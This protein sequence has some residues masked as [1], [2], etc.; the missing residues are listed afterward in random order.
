MTHCAVINTIFH[1]KNQAHIEFF[2]H[3]GNQ[4]IADV[5]PTQRVTSFINISPCVSKKFLKN[6]VTTFK[7]WIMSAYDQI[8]VSSKFLHC[9]IFEYL[10]H[11]NEISNKMQGYLS[12]VFFNPAFLSVSF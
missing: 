9:H 3:R 1:M 2:Q 12:S 11:S 8:S 10:A 6:N 7:K 5:N 4:D